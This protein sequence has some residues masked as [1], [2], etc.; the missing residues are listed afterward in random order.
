MNCNCN[1]I[2]NGGET[3]NTKT[4]NRIRRG[5]PFYINLSVRLNGEDATPEQLRDISIY[6]V[7]DRGNRTHLFD[8]TYDDNVISARVETDK[9]GRYNIEVIYH[10]NGRRERVMDMRN[11]VEIVA[12]S[13]DE[14]IDG[15]PISTE[16][17]GV[18]ITADMMVSLN[19]TATSPQTPKTLIAVNRHGKLVVSYDNAEN[20]ETLMVD[21]VIL[22]DQQATLRE[23]ITSLIA[24]TD[25]PTTTEV[26]YQGEKVPV[27]F[28]AEEMERAF[29]EIEY[30]TTGLAE[31]KPQ[32]PQT[33]PTPQTKIRVENGKLK[34][35]YDDGNRWTDINLS[36]VSVGVTHNGQYTSNTLG[37]LVRNPQLS[38]LHKRVEAIEDKLKSSSSPQSKNVLDVDIDTDI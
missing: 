2:I 25:A 14:Q 12:N 36:D 7:D 35:S 27:S 10:P 17:L 31:L 26:T 15:Q 30:I 18:N 23:I 6:M 28:L 29:S 22:H 19:A 24:K 13:D 4:L 20:W 21:N 33:S 8:T 5:N 9:V 32:T 38:A 37:N 1:N 16:V 3:N 11:V 34:V